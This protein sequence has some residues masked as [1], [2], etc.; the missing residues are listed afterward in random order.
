MP[1]IQ[2]QP[3]YS[4]SIPSS[5][6]DVRANVSGSEPAAGVQGVTGDQPPTEGG[7]LNDHHGLDSGEG[8]V[9]DLHEA[10]VGRGGL[11]ST[12]RFHPERGEELSSGF[13]SDGGQEEQATLTPRQIP[14]TS[15]RARSRAKRIR[16]TGALGEFLDGS[17]MWNDINFM[18]A[19]RRFIQ[20]A[21]APS[22]SQ[23]IQI[24]NDD[25]SNSDVTRQPQQ[26]LQDYHTDQRV[27]HGQQGEEESKGGEGEHYDWNYMIGA[28]N[29]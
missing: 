1:F 13:F 14:R 4:G 27:Q 28:G 22:G 19:E 10:D 17:G 3:S 7:E 11:G 6:A 15:S 24:Q 16:I 2:Q 18:E 12:R 20:A 23:D 8:G 26:Q 9:G 29:S 21:A 5:T 25:S